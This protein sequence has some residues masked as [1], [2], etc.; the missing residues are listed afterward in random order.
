MHLYYQPG[1]VS[2]P[3]SLR[4][5]TD[6]DYGFLYDL[7]AATIKACV[8]ATWGWDDAVQPTMF[9]ER[10]NPTETQVVVVDSHDVGTVAGRS[11]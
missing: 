9:R 11:E 8:E 10:W 5:A 6:A 2:L 7:H 3:Y 1:M 4:P